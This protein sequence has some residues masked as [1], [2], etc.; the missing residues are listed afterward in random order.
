MFYKNARI[1]GRDFQ[2]HHGAFEV[3]D[4]KFGTVFPDTVPD[5][6]VDLNNATVIPGLKRNT[7]TRKPSTGTSG[8]ASG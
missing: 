7:S 1:Y 6:A 3:I 8:T 4:G 5:D 2:F